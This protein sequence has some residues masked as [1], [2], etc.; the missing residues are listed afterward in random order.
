MRAVVMTNANVDLTVQGKSE[1]QYIQVRRRAHCAADSRIVVVMMVVFV[2]WSVLKALPKHQNGNF[3]INLTD[4]FVT[5]YTNIS[6][7]PHIHSRD[8]RHTLSGQ[9]RRRQG[10]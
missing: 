5:I 7:T 2:L 3:N 1:V 4:F 8:A 10:P 9:L 6:P